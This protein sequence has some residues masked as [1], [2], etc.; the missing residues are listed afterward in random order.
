MDWDTYSC[1]V[2]LEL[3]SPYSTADLIFLLGSFGH[4]RARQKIDMNG[5][6]DL[7][8]DVYICGQ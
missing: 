6:A 5:L 3:E 2:S 7:E 8:S 4:Q 1:N